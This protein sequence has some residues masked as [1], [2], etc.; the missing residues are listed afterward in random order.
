M[1][2]VFTTCDRCNEKG[3]LD[4]S[5]MLP[6]EYCLALGL[7]PGYV[8]LR[9]VEKCSFYQAQAL[10]WVERDYGYCCPRCVVEEREEAALDDT[11]VGLE[12]LEECLAAGMKDKES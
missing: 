4:N 7:H 1:E 12:A 11:S 3:D 9:G 2:I 5:Q 10:G 6:E 8:V